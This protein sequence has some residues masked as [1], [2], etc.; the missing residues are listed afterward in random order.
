MRILEPLLSNRIPEERQFFVFNFA[1]VE[2]EVLGTHFWHSEEGG[3]M[4]YS[5]KI[6]IGLNLE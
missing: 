3:I 4:G 1:N 5:L 2:F 6:F